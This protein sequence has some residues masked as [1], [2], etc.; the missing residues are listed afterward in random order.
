LPASGHL[1]PTR[2]AILADA[3]TDAGC[4][5]TDVLFAEML[6]SGKRGMGS[7]IRPL[8]SPSHPLRLE[9]SQVGTVVTLDP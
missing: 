2:L 9:V 3:L 6:A 5:N 7:A 4:D 8:K 1:D